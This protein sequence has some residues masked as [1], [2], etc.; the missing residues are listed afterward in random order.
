[1]TAPP[2]PP[3]PTRRPAA[4]V[5]LTL[6]A[7]PLLAAPDPAGPPSPLDGFKPYRQGA[8]V[9]LLADTRQALFHGTHQPAVRA[10][11]EHDLLAFLASDAHPQAKAIAAEWL[12]CLG[13]EAALPALQ[14]LLADPALA[15]PAAAAI[16]RITGQPARAPT[17][18]GPP[19]P[20]VAA[21]VAFT[22]DA[23]R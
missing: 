5:V 6:L 21:V 10:A 14:R 2:R 16:A 4:A 13:S 20:A 12:G 17:P 7:A 18:A 11:R 3:A 15:Q 9:A 22:K 1:M 19:A 23:G 8:P